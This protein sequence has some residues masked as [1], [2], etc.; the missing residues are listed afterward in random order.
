MIQITRHFD[1]KPTEFSASIDEN[2]ILLS[3]EWR[4]EISEATRAAEYAGETE[5]PNGTE[6]TGWTAICRYVLCNTPATAEA[7]TSALADC[8]GAYDDGFMDYLTRAQA[9]AA[10]AAINAQ[11]PYPEESAE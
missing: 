2:G 11:Y 6:K 4:K 5:A 10:V 7:I 9:F 3:A 8:Y 1:E